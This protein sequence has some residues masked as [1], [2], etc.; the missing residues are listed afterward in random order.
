MRPLILS[1]VLA[2]TCWSADDALVQGYTDTPFLPG[3][4]WHVHDPARPQPTIISGVAGDDGDQPG[5][6]PSD[7]IVLFDGSD[8]RKWESLTKGGPIPWIV[9]DG[10]LEV[11]PGSGDIRTTERFGDCQLHVE[12][13]SPA[14]RTGKGNDQGNSGVRFFGIYEVQVFDSY[15]GGIYADGQAAAVYGQTPPLVNASRKPGV[16]QVYDIL[17]TA[18]R[19]EGEK[20]TSPAFVTV[21]HNGVA[22]QNHTPI[23]GPT[24]YRSR[25][26][27]VPHGPEGFLSLQEHGNP[28]RY[29]NIWVRRLAAVGE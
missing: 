18:P 17:F 3:D 21:F 5:R 4:R 14:P 19:F 13:A 1:I 8:A 9:A 6:P 10:V 2:A 7:A 24:R 12:W 23:L 11:V 29:R 25:L 16:W 27:Y 20:L 22:V 15:H 26:P 28:V